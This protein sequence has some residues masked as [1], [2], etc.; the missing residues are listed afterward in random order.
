MLSGNSIVG[1]SRNSTSNPFFYVVFCIIAVAYY[2]WTWSPVLAGFGGDNATYFLTANLFSPY[3]EAFPVSAYFANSSQ[4]PPLY[5]LLLGLSGG[6]DS[7]LIAHLITT[8]FL[9]IA[10]WLMYKWAINLNLGRVHA[11]ALITI[12]STIPGTY[13]QAMSILSENLYLLLSLSGLY[14][15]TLKKSNEKW[16]WVSAILIAA[17]SLTRSAGLSLILSFIIYLFISKDRKKYSLSLGVIL[18]MILWNVLNEQDGI[19]YSDQ[20]SEFYSSGIVNSMLQHITSQSVYMWNAWISIFTRGEF[21]HLLLSIYAGLC[22]IAICYRLYMKKL[23]GLYSII[24]LSMIM[25]WPFPD[26]AER[27]LYPVI[28]VLLVQTGNCIGYFTNKWKHNND[29]SISNIILE[30]TLLIIIIPN[31]L[32]T[33]NRFNLQ[34]DEYLIP[35]KRTYAWYTPN[36]THAISI[37]KGNHVII[38]SIEDAQNYVAE[39]Q[40]VYSIKPSIIGLYMR[41]ISIIPPGINKDGNDFYGSIEKS[42]CDYFYFMSRYSASVNEVFYPYTR[43]KDNIDLVKIYYLDKKNII[44]F[45]GR[46]KD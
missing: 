9:L 41:R 36:L 32:L 15:A 23:D 45:L 37:S 11:L 26:E 7:I 29:I 40:C 6:G 14:V 12:M 46:L 24:Y 18:P 21:G 10:I 43:V 42:G 35:Y 27:L 5:P 1:P 8:T 2:V 28:P 22:F 44:A 31:L 33:I 19:S 13:F 20:F 17:S 3:S 30:G 34:I 25:S 38:S 39:D 4:Y 16:M